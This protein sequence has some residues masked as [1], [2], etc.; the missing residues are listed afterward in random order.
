MAWTG[1]HP[2]FVVEEFFK[3]KQS[4][5]RALGSFKRRFNLKRHD[6]VP[7]YNSIMPSD[8]ESESEQPVR[9]LSLLANLTVLELQIK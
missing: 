1:I 8:S 6:P 7:S 5:T 4:M 9:H 2:A 3:T